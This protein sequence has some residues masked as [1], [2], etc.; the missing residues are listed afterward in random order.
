MEFKDWTKLKQE[1]VYKNKQIELNEVLNPCLELCKKWL[2]KGLILQ[3]RRLEGWY[4]DGEP[5]IEIWVSVG[6]VLSII[7]V[8]CKKSDGTQQKNQK[9]YERKYELYSNVKYIIVRS[10]EELNILI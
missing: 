7:M 9:N 6:D 8:E 3:Y 10:L 2:E 5:D 4:Q 1:K